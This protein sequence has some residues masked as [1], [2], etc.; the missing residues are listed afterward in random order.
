MADQE[1]SA[2]DERARELYERIMTLAGEDRFA[3]LAEIAADPATRPLLDALDEA[4]EIRAQSHLN[5]AERWRARQQEIYARRLAEAR[6]ALDGLDMEL[7][8][9]L[10]NR[11]DGRFLTAEQTEEWDELLLEIEARARELEP[12]EETGHRLAPA[13]PGTT[14]GRS[15][16]WRRRRR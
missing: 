4:S 14:S 3:E 2:P 9:G 15:P 16:W 10:M 13:K 1:G 12:L 7:A 5:S 6:R 8:R 11:I